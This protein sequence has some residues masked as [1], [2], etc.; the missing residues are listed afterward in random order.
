LRRAA[1]SAGGTRPGSH[2]PPARSSARSDTPSGAPSDARSSAA[3]IALAA[4]LAACALA[5]WFLAPH[6]ALDWQPA[7]AARE[8]WRALSAVAV[9]YGALHLAANLAGA[10]AVGALGAAARMPRAGALAWAAAWPLTQ[11]GLL[12]QPALAHYGG[13]SGVLH[14]GVA[15]VAAQL[16][17]RPQPAAQR[18]VGAALLAGLALKIALEAPWDAPLRALPALGIAVAPAAH[19]SGAVAGLLCGLIAAG[20]GIRRAAGPPAPSNENEERQRP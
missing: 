6:G 7:R 17:V 9:H 2:P 16:L 19:A 4:L 5:G 12:A 13:L 1:S 10:A 15:V 11:L 18:A 14:A 20:L 3:W 8:P